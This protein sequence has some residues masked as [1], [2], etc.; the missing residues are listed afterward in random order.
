MSCCQ[1]LAAL[2]AR[3]VGSTYVR[4]KKH[5]SEITYII[6]MKATLITVAGM[7]AAT[8]AFG[9]TVDLKITGSTA[10]RSVTFN[11]IKAMYGAN[12]TSQNPSGNAGSANQ[13]TFSGK[14]PA[15]FGN[16]RTVIIRTGY[17]GSVEG[18]RDLTQN[19]NVEFLASP[20]AGDTTKLNATADF[21]LSD[22]FQSTTDYQTPVLDDQR[23]GIVAFS[24]VRSV[25]CPTA[26]ANM[27]HQQAQ[28]FLANGNLP[29]SFFTGN[30]ADTTSVYLVG[31]NPGSGTR[32]VTQADCG[33][34][35]TASSSLFQ[36]LGGVWTD[37]TGFTSGSGVSGLLNNATA[38]TAAN[39]YS[40]G[41]LG[42]SDALN[43]NGGA[44]QLTFNG[45]ANTKDAV[46]R[47]QYSFWA[48]QH[49]FTK[50]SPSLDATT[51]R[52]GANGLI[53]AIDTFLANDPTTPHIRTSTM[54]VDR[55]ADGGPIAP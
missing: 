13:V 54:L 22:V 8:A 38:N 37:H 33:Y 6:K 25:N 48:P 10:F 34:G 30:P 5:H 44:N 36:F 49:L 35:A 15:L 52:D 39:G 23:V 43:V 2:E 40:I 53:K 24:W 7:C 18:V 28:L 27:T 32:A 16:S 31:R 19:A 29:L 45:V 46:R 42:A 11:S 17:T 4:Y 9:Q 1:S 41:Y 20:N 50:P 26:V 12:L 14:I 55:Q 51:F 3:P 21:A 47:G